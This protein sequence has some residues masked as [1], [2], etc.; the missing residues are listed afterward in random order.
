M[1]TNRRLA[2]FRAAALIASYLL[3]AAAAGAQQ[4][5]ALIVGGGPSPEHNQVGIESN[6]RYLL[7]LLPSSADRTVLFADGD[8]RSRT[9]LYEDKGKDSSDAEQVLALILHG[10]GGAYQA[11][12][13][14][15]ATTIPQV[16]GSCNKADFTEALG[17]ISAACSTAPAPVLLY[18]TGHGSPDKGQNLDNNVYDMWGDTMSVRDLAGQV[19]RLPQ[20]VPV[21]LVMVQC[22]SGAFGNLLF[23]GGDPNGALADRDFAG[24]FATVNSR[25]SAGCTPTLDEGDYHDFTGYFFAALSGQDRLGRPVTGADYNHDGRVTMDEAFAYALIHD[26]SIDVPVCTSDVFLRRF[27]TTPDEQ[28][29]KTPYTA[30]RQWATPAQKVALDELSRSLRLA[31]DDR[32]RIAYQKFRGESVEETDS[33]QVVA[34]R[35][36]F[37]IALDDARKRLYERWPDLRDPHSAGYAAARAEALEHIRQQKSDIKLGEFMQCIQKLSNAEDADYQKE[38]ADARMMRFVRLYKSV[39]LAHT[40]RQR[41][42]ANLKQRYARLTAAEGRTLLAPQESVRTSSLITR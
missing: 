8:R 30:V 17:R 40:L 15:R 41:D 34:A 22:F 20:D 16:D 38:L 19:A 10:R 14:L 29:F 21:T 23:Q 33:G 5:R 2:G 42:D 35:R 28:V 9:V 32:G 25:M 4:I 39:V 7:R 27:V 36:D 3:V 26:S 11:S 37:R 6:V 13:K 1:W 18:F 12:E 24:F 31:G